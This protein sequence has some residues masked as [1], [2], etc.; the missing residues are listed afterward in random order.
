MPGETIDMSRAL[1]ARKHRRSLLSLSQ[2]KQ[3]K[4]K[5]SAI[6]VDFVPPKSKLI[7]S[8]TPRRSTS[9]R[10]IRKKYRTP[11]VMLSALELYEQRKLATERELKIQEELIKFADSLKI[12]YETSDKIKQ[13]DLE[14]CFQDNIREGTKAV[15]RCASWRSRMMENIKKSYRRDGFTSEEVEAILDTENP[16]RGRRLLDGMLERAKQTYGI[17][18]DDLLKFLF[19]FSHNSQIHRSFV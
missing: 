4:T 15:Q 13:Q 5:C 6:D 9:I 2:N 10:V 16:E 14:E 12:Q 8:Y 7:G 19:V 1:L 17:N 3:Q 18:N 11:F